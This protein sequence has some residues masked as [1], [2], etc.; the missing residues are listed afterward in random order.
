MAKGEI[1]T[2]ADQYFITAPTMQTSSPRYSWLNHVQCVGKMVEVKGGE[3]AY[4]KYD[5]FIVR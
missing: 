2:A 4:V 5:I 1:M 3:N